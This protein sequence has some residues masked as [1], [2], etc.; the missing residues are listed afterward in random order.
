MRESQ[1]PFVGTWKLDTAHSRFGEHH[2]PTSGLMRF[3]VDDA[4]HYQMTA[5]GTD[6]DGKRVV[7]RPQRLIPDGCD[8][9]LPNFA[10]LV[11]KTVRLDA[12]TLRS[13]CRREDGSIVGQGVFVVSP[14]GRRLTSTNSGFDSQLRKFKQTTVWGRQG[15]D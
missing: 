15:A 10:G 4:G 6:R 7:E 8:Y 5:E 14:D 9:P 13:E 12:R 11:V 3:E 2:R 1:D